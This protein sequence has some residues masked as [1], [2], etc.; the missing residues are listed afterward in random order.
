MFPGMP[1]GPVT[2]EMEK[3]MAA[4]I[5]QQVPACRTQAQYNSFMAAFDA[6]RFYINAIFVGQAEGIDAAKKTFDM[7]LEVAKGVTEIS[8]KLR[9]VPEAALG[10]EADAFKNPPTK[11]T[12]YDTQKQLMM[13]LQKIGTTEELTTWYQTNRA[14]I[15]G[16]ASQ[17]L[18]NP[19]MDLIREKKNA[20]KG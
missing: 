8:E 20:L 3:M 4:A 16:V 15:E 10:P 2:P 13:E 14:R 9:D 18:R 11:F 17:D 1:P 6:F 7:A 5:Q 12:E 19:L